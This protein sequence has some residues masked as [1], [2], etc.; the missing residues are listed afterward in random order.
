M[1]WFR[2]QLDGLVDL[3][4]IG[5]FKILNDEKRWKLCCSSLVDSQNLLCIGI[6]DTKEEALSVLDFI[7]NI[8]DECL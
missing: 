4:K 2:T 5:Y 7:E 3:A 1:I 6:Y 8:L